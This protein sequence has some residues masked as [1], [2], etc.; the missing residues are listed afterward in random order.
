M[1]TTSKNAIEAKSIFLILFSE[2]IGIVAFFILAIIGFTAGAIGGTLLIGLV[3]IIASIIYPLVKLSQMVSE[4]NIMCAED[5]EHLMPYIGA[6]LLGFVTFGIYPIYYM[7]R[8]QT[9][10]HENAHRYNVN[11]SEKGGAIIL[12]ILLGWFIFGIGIIVAYAIIIKNFNKMAYGY[13]KVLSSEGKLSG[14]KGQLKCIKGDMAGAE[15]IMDANNSAII[16]GRDPSMANVVSA[17][18]KISKQHCIVRFDIENKAFYVTDC[19]S[20]NG[21][22]LNNG[23]KLIGGK[24]T[25]ISDKEQIVLSENTVFTVE[26]I[27]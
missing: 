18:K 15:I 16:I 11:V 26:V 22:K 1:T 9:R 6:F 24:E 2:A 14:A 8:M 21:T 7:Y 13:N 10:L 4:I 5:G 27:K 3:V 19:N 25:K 17:D 23:A 20:T 12:W